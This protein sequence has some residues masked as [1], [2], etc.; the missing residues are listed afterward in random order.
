[1]K[2]KLFYITLLVCLL[3][4]PWAQAVSVKA[5]LDDNEISMGDDVTIAVSVSGSLNTAE[6]TPPK[7]NGLTFHKSGRTSQI[8][9]TNGKMEITAE[10]IYTVVPQ[11]EGT[12]K[13]PP[14]HV[15]AGGQGFKSN[16][17]SL[18]VRP[19]G[20][21]TT[22]A[23]TW[24]NQ[25]QNI[26]NKRPVTRPE[27]SDS[28]FWLQTTISK[29]NPFES[30]Q[31][32][33]SFKL[34]TRENITQAAPILPEF[35][36]FLTEVLVSDRRGSEVV[37]GRSYATWEKVLAIIPLKTGTLKIPS[38]EIDIV[39]Q[40]IEQN[41]KPLNRWDPFFNN[42][43][44]NSAFRKTKK[45]TLKSKELT[46]NVQALPK[47]LPKN[48]TGLVGNFG[49]KAEL[50]DTEVK[51]GESV[52]LAIRISGEGNIK[53]GKLPD[54]N[55]EGFKVYSD[56]PAV[57]IHKSDRGLSGQK[58]FKMALVPQTSGS[59]QIP[60]FS[61]SYFDPNQKTYVPIRVTPD[62]IRVLP[63]EKQQTHSVLPT[64]SSGAQKVVYQDIAPIFPDGRT[65]LGQSAL[66]VPP[67][68]FY[69]SVYGLPVA[70]LMVGL[71]GFLGKGLGKKGKKAR[72]KQAYKKMMDQLSQS[73]LAENQILDAIRQYM[74]VAFDV[75]GQALTAQEMKDLCLKS[76]LAPQLSER[77]GK[78]IQD[79]EAVQYGFDKDAALG[80]VAKDLKKVMSEVHKAA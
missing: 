21:K 30:E 37:N 39:Y 61:V 24:N 35:D 18:T 68:V 52:T 58:T 16:A 28:K 73:G 62:A 75:Q 22:T 69:A 48:Y 15:F 78:S 63:A 43:F 55:F 5:S 46:L 8:Q 34:Y 17:L 80:A 33:Y 14:F 44:F 79:L 53:E 25:A 42:S 26:Q 27:D 2:T 38:A 7:V 54:L 9:F 65:V 60:E 51:Q 45:A 70:F 56:K 3:S 19:P 12:Y 72:K 71:L 1:M 31:I 76:Q 29:P 23:P 74:S 36:D 66:R 4:S 50:S 59:I 40:V 49:V 20:A 77:L 13:I 41:R 64:S 6:P 11:K 57:D 47:P 32:L 10:F 67:F